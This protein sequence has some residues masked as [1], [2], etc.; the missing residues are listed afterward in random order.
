MA[1]PLGA[2]LPAGRGS[3]HSYHGEQAA[4]SAAAAAYRRSSE[5]ME[6]V[7][8]TDPAVQGVAL[9]QP[10]SLLLSAERVSMLGAVV[11]HPALSHLL[12]S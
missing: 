10:C 6:S 8:T 1:C 4:P 9:M 11:Q 3:G 12:I 5:R 7:C 2:V